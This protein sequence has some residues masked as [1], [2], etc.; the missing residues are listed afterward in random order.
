MKKTGVLVCACAAA[1]FLAP[2][3]ALAQWAYLDDANYSVSEPSPLPAFEQH[4]FPRTL[5]HEMRGPTTN[6]EYGKYDFIDGHGSVFGRVEDIQSNFSPDTMLLRHISA[7]AYQ[8]FNANFC[9]ISD[10]VAFES[11][12]PVTQGGPES[13]GC[14][15]FAGH[16]LY[17]AGTTL[18]EPMSAQAGSVRVSDPTRLIA[19]QYV[20]IYDAPAGSFKNAEH[21]KVT[22]VDNATGNVSL[23]KRGFKSTA[24]ARAAGAVIA[25]HIRGQGPEPLL[26]AFNMSA[27]CPTD[28]NG[29]TFGS[30]YAKWLAK[31]YD[32]SG[33]GTRT[34]AKVAGILFDADKYFEL[35]DANADYNNDLIV[36]NGISADGVNW[37]GVGLDQFYSATR[38]KLPALHILTGVHDGRGYASNNGAQLETWIDV[39]NGDFTPN[40]K[41]EQLNSMFAYYLFNMAERDV[42]PPLV[43]NLTK[44]PTAQYPGDTQANSNAPFRLALALTLMENGYFGTHSNQASDGWWDEFAVDVQSGSPNYGAAADATDLVAVDASKGW[45]GRPTGEFA[46][47]YEAANFAPAKSL[48]PNG[49]IEDGVGEWSGVNTTVSATADAFE[50][51]T[52]L[53]AS[54]MTTFNASP[55]ATL[56]KSERLS[57][58]AGKEYTVAFAARAG[59]RRDIR[60]S[61]GAFNDK[62]PIGENWRRYVASFRQG[63]DATSTLRFQIGREDTGIWFD[64][65]Y[66]FEG[67]ANVFRRDFENG[68][69]LANA[70]PLAKTIALDGQF[71][72]IS[73]MQ[74]PLVNDGSVV[75][76]LTLQ[77]YDGI[78]LVRPEDTG[79]PPAPSARI[80][81][82]VWLDQDGDGIQDAEESGA[83]AVTVNLYD[84]SNGLIDTASSGSDGRY[85]FDELAAGDY[86]VEFIAPTGMSLSPALQG[87]SRSIDSN[88]DRVTG[89][90]DCLTMADA[91]VRNG[92]DAGLV[93]DEVVDPP[94]VRNASIGDFVWLDANENGIQ[95]GDEPGLPGTTVN[96]F[97]CAGKAVGTAVTGAKG[98]YRFGDL[99][100]GD[101]QLEFV[102]P[103]GMRL[104]RSNQ[105]GDAATDSDP[106]QSN[107]LT[108]C[109]LIDRSADPHRH[110]RRPRRAGFRQRRGRRFLDQEH[111]Q[112]WWRR[113]GLFVCL[114]RLVSTRQSCVRLPLGGP[115]S[116]TLI[117]FGP[118]TYRR[119]GGAGDCRSG[120][121][122]Q[123][124]LQDASR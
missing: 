34:T 58:T 46:R 121:H 107:G 22:A 21:A 62:F 64:S 12:G 96:L 11:T 72:K 119:V 98:D 33:D 27:E 20:V 84:C 75:T 93:V 18:A 120:R 90:T 103:D 65:I 95:D 2:C 92:V 97:D 94:P 70:T 28:G 47:V 61:L 115:R 124:R 25:T 102:A 14:D 116:Q 83:S 8:G 53:K 79:T 89:R 80:G 10:G 118:L 110:R 32:R 1:V 55:S 57:L 105:G 49:G 41:Y 7:R 114:A 50:G 78:L 39:G 52:A 68:I 85:Q 81:D 54:K 112:R 37:L 56:V 48:L 16:W 67:S 63:A 35:T 123:K 31:N 45:L 91:Q 113:W 111:C 23:T 86:V 109:L 76:E 43:H 71:L 17:M 88:P 15:F 4:L 106:A 99:G 82:M 40:P 24:R 6:P 36:D 38:A 73:G 100:A 5:I 108:V 87:D 122:R 51:E 19:G 9:R 3:A 59:S 69:V 60:V 42:R 29:E 74:D 30:F 13:A 101:Y 26:W 44:T 77:P 117:R 104:T 66:V